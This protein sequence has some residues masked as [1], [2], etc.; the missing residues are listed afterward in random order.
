MNQIFAYIS[1]FCL[2]VGLMFNRSQIMTEAILILP[3]NVCELTI[4]LLVNAC[5]WNGFLA[6]ASASGMVSRMSHWMMP[7]FKWV[8]P[9]L[10]NNAEIMGLVASNFIA[11]FLGLGSLAMISGLK[12]IKAM[13]LDNGCQKKASRSMKTL[14][15]FNTT[16]CSL[17]SMSIISM[18]TAYQA[19]DPIGFIGW[20]LLIGVVTLASGIL[21]QKGVE[22]FG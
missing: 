16:G 22:H 18:R 7:F 10:K 12:A 15:I 4:R 9:D 21:I 19:N 2:L 17:F 3:M 14:I 13:D 8:Y 1:L 11:N 20:T 5:M 6:L